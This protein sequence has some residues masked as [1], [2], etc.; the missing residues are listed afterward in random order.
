RKIYGKGLNFKISLVIISLKGDLRENVS[1]IPEFLLISTETRGYRYENHKPT[2]AAI[3]TAKMGDV[4]LV[5]H[6][7]VFDIVS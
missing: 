1:S 3:E 5:D 4:F 6:V 7:R 2:A